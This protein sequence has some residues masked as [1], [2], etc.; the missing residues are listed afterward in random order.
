[1]LVLLWKAYPICTGA[2]NSTAA[3]EPEEREPWRGRALRRV[4]CFFFFVRV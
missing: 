2:Q 1:V 4:F 3:T